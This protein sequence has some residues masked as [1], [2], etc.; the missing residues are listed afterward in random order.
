MLFVL[1]GAIQTGKTRWLQ[2]TIR[3]LEN[4]GVLSYGV[5]APGTWIAHDEGQ[6]ISYEKTGIDNELLPGHAIVPFARRN[7][8]VDA[9]NAQEHCTQAQRAQLAWAIDDNAIER[10]NAHFEAI[11]QADISKPG[12]LIVDEFGRLELLAGEGL[13]SAL[14]LV[15]RG[16]TQ[17]LPHALIVVREQLLDH[18]RKRFASSGW[19]E[20]RPIAP[21]EDAAS[22]LFAV[23][24][25]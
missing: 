7:D 3:E 5:V 4:R 12:L 22:E 9:R 18:A 10:V 20:I 14:Q 25:Q 11:A 19:G 16:P 17:Q 23:F 15:D 8:L 24:Q 6:G 1:T 2:R 21:N 13:T